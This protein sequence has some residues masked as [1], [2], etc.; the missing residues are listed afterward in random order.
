ML[1]LLIFDFI[2]MDDSRNGF[3]KR[4][5]L[6]KS[7]FNNKIRQKLNFLDHLRKHNNTTAVIL[8][9]TQLNLKDALS[10]DT[11]IQ[12]NC[13]TL[14]SISSQNSFENSL[15]VKHCPY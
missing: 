10:K 13:A 15:L 1:V 5:C 2:I 11:I 6:S 9:Q 7:Q 12:E 8:A 14:L 3:S 4:N